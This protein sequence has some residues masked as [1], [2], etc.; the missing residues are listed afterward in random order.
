MWVVVNYY[1]SRKGNAYTIELP[2]RM[3]THPTFYVGR[4]R[5]YHHHDVS[6]S[7]EYNRHVQEPP[8]DS[9]GP[10]PASQYGSVEQQSGDEGQPLRRERLDASARSPIDRTRTPIGLSIDKCGTLQP[11]VQRKTLLP[12]LFG[13][14]T[15]IV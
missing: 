3:R 1:P 4:L 5:P 11:R 2:R 7:R 12:L 15:Q 9:F 6:S 14:I 8:G 10:E 13:A